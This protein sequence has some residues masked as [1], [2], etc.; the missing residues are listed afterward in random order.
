MTRTLHHTTRVVEGVYFVERV[1]FLMYNENI[2]PSHIQERK[3]FMKDYALRD[4]QENAVRVVM[5]AIQNGNKRIS[6]NM[7]PGTGKTIV[8]TALIEC[9]LAANSR[10]LI[11]TN[12]RVEEE[13]IRAFLMDQLKHSVAPSLVEQ[14][15][16]ITL[17]PRLKRAK[18]TVQLSDYSFVFLLDLMEGSSYNHL[19]ENGKATLIGFFTDGQSL[20][21]RNVSDERCSANLLFS[22]KDCVFTYSISEAVQQGVLSPMIDP[23]MYEPAT[24]GFCQ[25][26][27]EKLG[28]QLLSQESAKWSFAARI[29]LEFL[30]G[31]RKVAV[32]CKIGRYEY[33]ASRALNLALSRMTQANCSNANDDISL[34]VII[35][36]V[37]EQEKRIAYDQNGICVWDISNLLYYVQHDDPLYEELSKLSY[38]PLSGTIATPPIGWTPAKPNTGYSARYTIDR[39]SYLKKQ[40]DQCKS[41]T[42]CAAMY[43]K[44]CQ[45][46]IE[47][48]FPNAF[49]VISSQHKTQDEHFRM[50]LICSLRG[51]SETTHP[52]WKILSRHYNSHFVVFEFKNY[53]KPI[54]QN[55]IYI[56]EKYLFNAALRNVA[57]IISRQ[58]FSDSAKFAANGCLKENGKLIMSL[59]NSDL[60]EMLERKARGDNPEESLLR[61]LE[62][63]LMGISK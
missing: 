31:N 22:A 37:T 18:D 40:L 6:L 39:S 23:S 53:E 58:G 3:I 59:S 28:G 42:D 54:D 14:N 56:T 63:T 17:Y 7:A 55:L 8:L 32:E 51:E 49:Y 25:R 2:F 33:M 11:V 43:E 19:F 4:Y 52:F 27:F 26:L 29:D 62:A 57:I 44:I 61:I 35:G 1:T 30:F 10:V 13:R 20:N 38:F 15:V 24:I 48:L 9:L 16:C 36:K 12:T 46:I 47:F 60:A 21:V 41:G 5:Q 50:D 45:D 34:L